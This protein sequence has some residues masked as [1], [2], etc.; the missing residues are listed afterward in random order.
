MKTRLPLLLALVLLPALHAAAGDDA[1]LAR[2]RQAVREDD[3]FY[4]VK[5]GGYVIKTDVDEPFA[6]EAAVYM[7]GFYEAFRSFFKPRPRLKATPVV[8]LFKDRKSYQ[9]HVK[10]RGFD[11]LVKAG[12]A[13]VGSRTRSE[14]FC[15][16]MR[17]GKGFAAFPK[18]VLRHEGAHQLL[19]YILGTHRIPIWYNEGVATFFEGWDVEKPWKWNLENLRHTHIRFGR[20]VR[21]FGTD[22]FKDLDYLMKLTHKTWVPDDFG[23]RTEQH[24]AE[25]ESFMTFLLVTEK[26]RKFFTILFRAIARGRDPTD[27]LS[28]GL[29]RSAQEAWYKDIERR[30][31][32]F[33]RGS[34][35]THKRIPFKVPASG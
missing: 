10:T 5:Y 15:W 16:H 28:P 19:S 18:K 20:I 9:D 12:G 32:A 35:E 25:V 6:A 4:V 29:I 34:A 22:E 24:Y 13:Y 8:Y 26:G 33:K 7:R 3:D 1:E 14:L 30:I 31:A 17:P 23:K 21:T 2:I 11:R 27:M